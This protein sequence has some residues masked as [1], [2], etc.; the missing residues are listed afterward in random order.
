MTKQQLIKLLNNTH[1]VKLD[2]AKY[3]IESLKT[4]IQTCRM[5]VMKYPIRGKIAAQ[6]GQMTLEQ[7]TDYKN[8]Y[9]K[10]KKKVKNEYFT[11]TF[12]QYSYNT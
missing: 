5:P 11:S 10:V 12:I 7:Q 2:K 4:A 9:Y 3:T 8:K 6:W 1:K